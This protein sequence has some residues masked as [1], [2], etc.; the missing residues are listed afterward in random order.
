M[1]HKGESKDE[2]FKKLDEFLS[3]DLS[4][5]SGH[6]MGSMCTQPSDFAVEIFS[7]YIWK[8]LGDP[9]LF[10]GSKELEMDLI[11]T[12]GDLFGDPTVY[13]SMVSGGSEGNLIA[14]RIAKKMN[15]EIKNP[16]ILVPGS[17]HLSFLKAADLMNVK[18]NKA[19]LD[20]NTYNLNMDDYASKITSNTI[21][22]VGVAGTTGLGLIDPIEEIGKLSLENKIFFHVDAAFGGFVLPFME[23]QHLSHI[24]LWDFRIKDVDSITADPHKMG[25]GVIPSGGFLLRNKGL[26]EKIGFEIPYLAGG[27]F[28]H[29]TLSGTRPGASAISFWALMHHLGKDGFNMIVRECWDN[30]IYLKEN[31]ED[32]QGLKLAR[33]PVLNVLGLQF[34]DS[35]KKSITLLDKE[36]RKDGWALGIFKEWNFARIVLMPHVK[37]SHIDAFLTDLKASMKKFR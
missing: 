6:I 14:V 1:Q 32:I 29:L 13:G 8:N 7:K 15:P 28:K 3:K 17:A 31:I 20:P 9:G 30:T 34:D 27:S 16:E 12:L 33:N 26:M 35:N 37:R 10:P 21:M 24:P 19:E 36:L 23:E 4:Y 5:T 25:M 18:V 2:I 22:M 11:K